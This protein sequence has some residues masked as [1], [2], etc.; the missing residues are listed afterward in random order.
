[1][2]F[3]K[4]ASLLAFL[5]LHI[6]TGKTFLLIYFDLARTPVKVLF[7]YNADVSSA[8]VKIGDAVTPSENGSCKQP[9]FC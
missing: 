9:I 1:M 4:R 2:A 8:S 5:L 7:V 6:V 3:Q